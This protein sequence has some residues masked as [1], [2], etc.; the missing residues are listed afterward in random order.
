MD[1]HTQGFLDALNR[2]DARKGKMKEKE[3]TA[4][5]RS[6]IKI[7]IYRER[8][9]T[10]KLLQDKYDYLI[11]TYGVA[12]SKDKLDLLLEL[13]DSIKGNQK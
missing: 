4:Y 6:L 1:A 7:A 8:Q 11:E 9:G 3:L 12:I 10:I 13:I 2:I 5:E